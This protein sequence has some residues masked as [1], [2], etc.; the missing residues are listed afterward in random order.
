MEEES[1]MEYMRTLL[2]ENEIFKIYIAVRIRVQF[3]FLLKLIVHFYRDMFES[4][5]DYVYAV[6]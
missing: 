4:I 2:R 6:G 5:Y 1:C 3:T